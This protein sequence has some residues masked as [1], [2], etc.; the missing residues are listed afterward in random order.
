MFPAWVETTQ[1][2]AAALAQ[3]RVFRVSNNLRL[4]TGKISY[5]SPLQNHKARLRKPGIRA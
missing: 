3:S 1:A 4:E 2:I 5:N